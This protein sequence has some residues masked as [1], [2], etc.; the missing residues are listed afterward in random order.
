MT[1]I[2]LII[3]GEGDY[4]SIPMSGGKGFWCH[5]IASSGTTGHACRA[6]LTGSR[7]GMEHLERD[8]VNSK[9]LRCQQCKDAE[10]IF[11]WN[12]C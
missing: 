7:G 4:C 6:F 3:E 12:K 1:I 2:K 5:F 8:H 11:N 9:T 10:K